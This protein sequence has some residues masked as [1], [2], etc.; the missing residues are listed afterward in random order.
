MAL[1]LHVRALSSRRNAERRSVARSVFL[2]YVT[3]LAVAFTG[4]WPQSLEAYGVEILVLLV[5]SV[6]PFGLA[7]RDGFR[8]TGVGYSRNVTI[9]QFAAGIVLYSVSIAT[10]VVLIQGEARALFVVAVNDVLAML[11]GV[12][13]T[14]ELIFRIQGAAET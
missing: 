11:W 1:S 10:A 7:A 4:L 9:V 5:A 14:W 3:P 6:I 13:N 2:G 12:F 8:A